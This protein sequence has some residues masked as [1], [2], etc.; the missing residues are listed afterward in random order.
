M[1]QQGKKAAAELQCF[2]CHSVDGTRGIG[3]TWLGLYHKN[4]PLA[5]GHAI[6]V[7]EAYL[8][9]SMMDPMADLVLGYSPVMPTYQ[10]RA[11]G[12]QLAAIVEFIKSLQD[13][14]IAQAPK[15]GAK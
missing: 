6:F 1:V 13:D 4:E 3:P 15:G 14:R 12:P 7:D 2:M 11:T 10:G 9:K 8:T 5:D